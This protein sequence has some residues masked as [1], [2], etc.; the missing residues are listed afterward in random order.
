MYDGL[1]FQESLSTSNISLCQ[2]LLSNF[3]PRFGTLVFKYHFKYFVIMIKKS[4]NEYYLVQK[5]GKIFVKHVQNYGLNIYKIID[6]KLRSAG[7]Q[8]LLF[9]F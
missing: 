4:C 7:K 9:L 6:E 3:K 2:K 5:N 1:K 8:A